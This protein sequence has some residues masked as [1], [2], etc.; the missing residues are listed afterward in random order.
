M[1]IRND[2]SNKLIVLNQ[3]S[4]QNLNYFIIIEKD[5]IKYMS[6]SFSKSLKAIEDI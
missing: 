5:R 2:K 6:K 3:E 4:S 1:F